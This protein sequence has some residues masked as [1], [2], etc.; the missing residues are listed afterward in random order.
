MNWFANAWEQFRLAFL[1][2]DRYEAYFRGFGTTLEVSL[3]AVL[4]GVALGLILAIA[5]YMAA[6]HKRSHPPRW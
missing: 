6:N 4:L 5:K 1:E 3:F 2:K